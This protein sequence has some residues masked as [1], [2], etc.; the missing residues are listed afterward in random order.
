MDSLIKYS[1]FFEQEIAKYKFRANPTN[2]YDPLRYFMGLGGKRVRPLLT[3]MAS[4]LFGK[5]KEN[6]VHAALA[7]EFFHN[8]SLIHDDIMDEAPLRRGK[9]TVHEKWNTNSAILSGDV[10]LVNA[11]QQLSLSPSEYFKEVIDIFNKVA[12]EVCEGQQLDMDFETL[13][14]DAVTIDE[15][16]EMIRLKTSVLLGGALKI[17]A[18]L[19]GADERNAQLIYDFGENLGVAFQIQDDILDLFGDPEKF[20]KQIGGDIIS[21]KKTF[22][23]LSAVGRGKKNEIE[24]ILSIND[25]TLKVAAASKAI[26]EWGVLEEVKIIKRNYFQKAM[27]SLNEIQ[28]NEEMK[29]SLRA[30]ANQLIDREF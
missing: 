17:G 20:G 18:V 25:K 3:L 30:L 2:L 13:N 6:V 22:L 29:L 19:A 9:V 7:I 28:V 1:S 10:L 11:Y 5:S 23:V 24:S 14:I 26:Q 27:N 12:V 21:N 4:E 16:I 8:F 15:Y